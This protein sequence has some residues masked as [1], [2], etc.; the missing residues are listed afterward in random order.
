MASQRGE[1]APRLVTPRHAFVLRKRREPSA[2][3]AH[4]SLTL[5]NA[6]TLLAAESIPSWCARIRG[7][8]A[9]RATPSTTA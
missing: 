8:T 4:A 3:P 6:F 9:T 1:W 7:A 5:S 2:L